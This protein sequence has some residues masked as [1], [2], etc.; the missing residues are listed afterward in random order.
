ML[1][2]V[3]LLKTKEDFDNSLAMTEAKFKHFETKI[4]FESEWWV[5][6]CCLCRLH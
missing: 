3:T 1:N 5:I 4:H 2:S 6:F